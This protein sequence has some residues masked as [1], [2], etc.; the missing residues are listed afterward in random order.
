M[1]ETSAPAGPMKAVGKRARQLDAALGVAPERTALEAFG[2]DLAANVD[3]RREV[4]LDVEPPQR[5]TDHPSS[6]FR[7]FNRPLP[8]RE[9]LGTGQAGD[10]VSQP[11]HP[12]AFLVD[13][14]KG[15]PS[16][17]ALDLPDELAQL[18]RITDIPSEEHDGV[19]SLLAQN[20]P[21]EVRERLASD[22]DTEDVGCHRKAS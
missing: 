6:P 8:L 14:Q 17:N 20:T 18:L 4:D 21:L 12:P 9:D 3:D 2:R 13:H 1:P 11:R 10:Q 5:E 16:G 7:Q 15:R 19:G 22:T